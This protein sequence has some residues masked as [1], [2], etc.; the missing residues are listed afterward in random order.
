M[1]IVKIEPNDNG[2]H[3]IEDQS[4]RTEVWMDGYIEVP[5]SLRDVFLST[6]GYGDLVISEGVLIN[7][8]PGSPPT[9]PNPIAEVPQNIPDIDKRK[10]S[11]ANE[12]DIRWNTEFLTVDQAANLLLLYFAEDPV[13]SYIK[14]LRDAIHK[15]KTEVR[16]RF[17]DKI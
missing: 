14:P 15:K 16:R 2:Q 6:G 3:S 9:D 7:F 5:D 11:Y 8:I 17:P 13:H 10:W 12:A 4:H 1:T